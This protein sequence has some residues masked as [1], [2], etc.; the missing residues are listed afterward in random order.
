MKHL[1]FALLL[2]FLLAACGPVAQPIPGPTS[3]TAS[4]LLPTHSSTPAPTP[5][6]SETTF[7][8]VTPTPEQVVSV[9]TADEI[10]LTIHNDQP[11]S[12][13][14]G[15]PKP[16]W[17]AWGAQAFSVA[18]NGDFWLLDSAAQPQRL[19]HLFPPYDSP[20]IISLEGL[21]VGA[22]DVEVARDAIW[23]LGIASQPPR[24]L[25]LAIDG[26]TLGSYDLP[27]GLWP[28]DGL[29]GI[30]LAQDGTLLVELEAGASLYQLFDQN[31]Q[32]APQRLE[33]YTFAD[34]LFRVEASPF[35]KTGFVYA[36]D[37]R[38]EV[39]VERVLG[40]LDRPTS[41]SIY[42]DG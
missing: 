40:G 21:V 20:Q 2:P 25:K 10:L 29:T 31:G 32:V 4:A 16:D 39:T 9:P 34:R 33:G 27:K 8:T 11:Y 13:R 3:P 35:A 19:L 28:E 5:A 14:A 18:P 15:E 38:V 41:G 30:A 6:A 42:F 36:G 1:N 22:A 23:V 12:G 26:K 24:V 17:L 7:T 37:V